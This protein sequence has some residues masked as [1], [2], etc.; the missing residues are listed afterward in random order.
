M[1]ERLLYLVVQMLR[2]LLASRR[3]KA[4]T[5][6]ES[7]MAASNF[8]KVMSFQALEI[9]ICNIEL[10]KIKLILLIFALLQYEYLQ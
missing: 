3:K 9:Q 7:K 6:G 4:A 2:K 8:S 10:P 5:Y 1:I